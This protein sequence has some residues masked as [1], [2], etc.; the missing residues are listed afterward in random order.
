MNEYIIL[1]NGVKMPKVGFGVYQIPSS[2]TKRC[3]M[4]A[5][6]LGY[7]SIDT[8]QYYENEKEVGDAIRASGI[9]R[10]EIFVTTKLIG[11]REYNDSLRAIKDSL[12]ELNIEYIDLLLIHQPTGNYV[13]IYRA[14]EEYYNKGLLKAIGISNFYGERYLKLVKNCK[15]IPQVNQV[16]THVFRQQP[17]LRTLMEPYGTKLESW[18]PLASTRNNIFGNDILCKIAK[19]YNKSVAQVALRF[20]YQQDIIIIPKS[21]HKER[22][23]ENKNIFDFELTDSDMEAIKT[24][25]EGESLFGWW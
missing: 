12:E 22:M 19:K 14:M 8:A 9:P 18:S 10:N 25:D 6:S 20:L 17:E 2:I 23:E 5:L 4:D 7:R 16:E 11:C 13:E 3:V 21:T 1:N 24:L 15:I